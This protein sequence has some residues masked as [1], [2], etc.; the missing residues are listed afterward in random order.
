MKT[1]IIYQELEETIKFLVVE[2]D[3]SR[4]NGIYIN[5]MDND[6]EYVDEFCDFFY[7]DNGEYKYELSSDIGLIE[8]K[9]WNKV[10]IVT[11]IM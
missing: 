5:M 3:Y 9:E 4:F 2:G 1:L 6:N 8:N 10:A 7:K 11:F